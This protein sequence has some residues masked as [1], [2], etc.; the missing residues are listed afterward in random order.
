VVALVMIPPVRGAGDRVRKW[1]SYHLSIETGGI[2]EVPIREA[3]RR[4]PVSAGS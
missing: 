2:N 4:L 1:D 3:T